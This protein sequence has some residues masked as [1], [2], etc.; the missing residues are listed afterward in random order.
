MQTYTLIA[1]PDFPA[2]NIRSVEARIIG[3]DR[4]WLRLRWRL[5]GGQDLVIPPFAGRGRADELWQSTCFEA[6]LQPLGGQTYVELNLSPSERWAAYDFDA[7]RENMRERAFP[8]E[9]DCTIRQGS[10]MVIFD[11]AIPDDGLPDAPCAM[12]IGA[13]L[14]ETDGVKSYWA[15]S[16]GDG[17]PD[18]HDPTCFTA[19]LDAPEHS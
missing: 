16:H 6:F 4:Q 10:N 17:A 19:R 8:H 9:P 5:E 7:P 3:H 2:R 18:F 1:H 11:A 13:V 15:L 14:E 12:G